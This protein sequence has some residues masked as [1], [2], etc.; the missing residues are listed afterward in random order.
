MQ[1]LGL[2]LLSII[3]LF[4]KFCS[5][6]SLNFCDSSE[7]LDANTYYKQ[8]ILLEKE[9]KTGSIPLLKK[10]IKIDTSFA[11]AFFKIGELYYRKAIVSQYDILYQTH[12]GYYSRKATDN[13]IYALTLCDEIENFAAYFYLGELFFLQQEYPLAGYYL[14]LYI[15]KSRKSMP[16]FDMASKYYSN[17]LKWKAWQEN[18]QDISLIP[19]NICS[20][21]DENLPFLT[22]NGQYLYFTKTYEKHKSNSLY[23]EKVSELNLSFV[24]SIDSNQNFV[25]SEPLVM[26]WPFN[27]KT[28]YNNLYANNS[29]SL[30]LLTQ[31]HK[32]K[33]N[34]N[35][36]DISTIYQSKNM[37]GFWDEPQ[38][39]SSYIN[40]DNIFDGQPTLSSDNKLLLFVSNRPGGFG[41]TDIY[42]CHK[43]STGNWSKPKNI[44][45]KINTINDERTPFLHF[46][47]KTLYFS[48][49]G[50]F[51]LG[52][53]DFFVTRINSDGTWETPENLGTPINTPSDEQGLVIDARGIKGY[54]ASNSL[55]GFGGWDIY[56]TDIPKKFR[57]N[58]MVLLNGKIERF[59]SIPINDFI[60]EI[61]N[62]KKGSSYEILMDNESGTFSS[63][64]PKEDNN[65]YIKI[66]SVG[67]SFGNQFISGTS[68]SHTFFADLKLTPLKSGASFFL[69]HI[70]FDY[71]LQ[72]DYKTQ[73]ILNDF[74]NYLKQNSSLELK[75]MCVN[76]KNTIPTDLKTQKK[77]ATILYRYL[78][79]NGISNKRL[80]YKKDT[81][82]ISNL[83]KFNPTLSE[84]LLEVTNY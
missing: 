56:C 32:T 11:H 82:M 38:K 43:D 68:D 51:G 49:N 5:G 80:T 2:M 53:F 33:I 20:T 31:I 3:I 70:V 34:N 18:P 8:A 72:F 44:G 13:L 37:D 79:D 74:V 1:K 52:G 83:P 59:D 16:G 25:F 24:E 39:L 28:K 48:S 76:Q 14:E 63:I 36:I 65:F 12:T 41:G 6:Q 55:P 21:I 60:V 62:L 27:N 69:N 50:H 10:A 47:N 40:I 84:I 35:Y 23:F 54:F 9:N 45:S 75:I 77:K 29:N 81:L 46:D 22:S 57:P 30:M 15:K 66:K 58:E 61:V 19:I 64:I 71:N 26:D 67:Y 78:I 7:N 73:I 17:Y 4:I 42:Y